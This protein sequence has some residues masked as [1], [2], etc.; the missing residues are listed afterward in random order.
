[1]TV[2]KFLRLPGQLIAAR[3]R[4]DL[5][6][7]QAAATV[8]IC[9]TILSAMETGRR[10]P[11]HFEVLAKLARA[12]GLN[13]DQA[14]ELMLAAAHDQLMLSLRGSLLEPSMAL[15]SEAALV[16]RRLTEDE[17]AG[18]IVDLR[19][20]AESKERISALAQ[21]GRPAVVAPVGRPAM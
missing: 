2:K 1:M 19:Q 9:Q 17:V 16:H 6:Q 14:R 15:I 20:L 4:C 3:L 10:T 13:E 7:K 21:R 5:L 11:E 8:G 12:Y 18:L